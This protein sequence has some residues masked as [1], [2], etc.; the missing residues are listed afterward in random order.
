MV[1]T[2]TLNADVDVDVNVVPHVTPGV[3]VGVGTDVE[4]CAAK[5]TFFDH[6]APPNACVTAFRAL[7]CS[8]SHGADV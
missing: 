1:V 3:D 8:R 7:T 4:T 6:G 2:I 5:L